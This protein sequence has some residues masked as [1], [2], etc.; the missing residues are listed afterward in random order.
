MVRGWLAWVL[1]GVGA[2][3]VSPGPPAPPT[4]FDG[5]VPRHEDQVCVANDARGAVRVSELFDTTGLTPVL[6]Q[7][8]ARPRP[9]APPWPHLDFI[10][11]YDASGAP[12]ASG[13]WDFAVDTTSAARVQSELES[14]IRA[15]PGLLEA[16]G[17]RTRVV[18]AHRIAI[19][20][21]GPVD[22]LPHIHH[23]PGQRATGLPSNVS[24]WGGST[25]VREGDTLTAVVRIHVGRTGAVTRVE[26]LRGHDSALARARDVIHALRFD[27]ALRNGVPVEGALMQAFRF[28]ADP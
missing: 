7:W 25:Y 12:V 10:T 26:P 15:V 3:A 8:E 1:I 22:C 5:I 6:R 27:P 18:F 13:T 28:D 4:P 16:G 17:F 21:V 14:R 19:D 9:A 23:L 24:T 2:C 20:V 11:R